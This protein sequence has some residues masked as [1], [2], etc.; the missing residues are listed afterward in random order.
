MAQRDHNC[1]NRPAPASVA[2]RLIDR[3]PGLVLGV[4]PRHEPWPMDAETVRIYGGFDAAPMRDERTG[5]A[6]LL[7]EEVVSVSSAKTIHRLVVRK[8]QPRG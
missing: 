8:P 5:A 6:K 3:Y 1:E 7:D 4:S 2:F